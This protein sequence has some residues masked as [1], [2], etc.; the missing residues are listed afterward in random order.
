MNIKLRC[1]CWNDSGFENANTSSISIS[2]KQA[3]LWLSEVSVQ[4]CDRAVVA[5]S[6]TENALS[7]TEGLSPLLNLH[8]K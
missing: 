4:L 8:L 1:K 7:F 2:G 6:D 3:S 5:Q